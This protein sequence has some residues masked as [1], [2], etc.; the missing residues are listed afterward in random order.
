MESPQILF[1]SDP[2]WDRSRASTD[3]LEESCGLIT[4]HGGT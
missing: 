3:H 4:S 2:K 1:S